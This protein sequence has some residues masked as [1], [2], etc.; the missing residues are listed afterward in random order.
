MMKR[1]V[2][3]DFANTVCQNYIDLNGALD[4]AAFAC[5]GS[6]TVLMD[7]LSGECKFNEEKIP[8]LNSS[9]FLQ[10]WLHKR[11][12]AHDIPV[13]GILSAEMHV[14]VVVSNLNL[15][16]SYGR[17]LYSC[18]FDFTCRSAIRT[19][20]KLYSSEMRGEKSWGF[21]E[22]YHTLCRQIESGGRD[23]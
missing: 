3:Q 22:E 7:L 16:R 18:H 14:I 13:S 15:A 2:L 9:I 10:H 19:A 21:G 12:A 1:K 6:G 20:E 11:L 8:T 17:A 4:A 23:E 5:Y